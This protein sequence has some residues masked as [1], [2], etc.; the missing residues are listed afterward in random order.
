MIIAYTCYFLDPNTNRF[1]KQKVK[2]LI[3]FILI[4]LLLTPLGQEF[5]QIAILNKFIG[6][7]G[8]TIEENTTG[9][10]TKGIFEMINYIQTNPS[11]LFGI[12]YDKLQEL[13]FDTVSGLPKLLIAIGLLPF[14]VIIGGIIYFSKKYAQ[15]IYQTI[16][17]FM[18]FISMG[19]GQSHIMNPCLFSMIFSTYILRIQLSK[20]KNK[21]LAKI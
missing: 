2:K 19:L 16:L 10:R 12:G 20:Y 5:I 21:L 13:N 4:V 18:L 9:A 7:N 3:L 8:F 17:I 15:S 11:V 6:D 14:S 1:I